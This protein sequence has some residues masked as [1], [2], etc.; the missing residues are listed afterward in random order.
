MIRT[1][2]KKWLFF[3][4]ITA[5]NLFVASRT[6]IGAFYFIFWFMVVFLCVNFFWALASYGTARLSVQR[7]MIARLQEEETL[8]IE[9]LVENKG[10]HLLSHLLIEDTLACAIASQRSV[11]YFAVAVAAKETV[12]FFTQRSCP[13][14]GRYLL[15]PLVVYFFDP[16]GL[17]FFKR[18]YPV[19]QEL[20]VYPK[21]SPLSWFPSLR[22][23]SL[24]W[25]GIE[26]T[27]TS[28]DEDEFFGIREYHAGD[29]MRRIHWLST[30][31]KNQLIVKQFQRQSFF[32]ATLVFTLEKERNYGDGKDSVAEYILRLAASVARHLL[33]HNVAVELLAHTGGL[34]HIPSSRGVEQL[35]DILTF[36]ATAQPEGTTS[37][38]EVFEELL[39]QVPDDANVIVIMLDRDWEYLIRMLPLEKRNIF[40]IPLILVSSTFRYAFEKEELLADIKMKLS[41]KFNFTPLLFS[42]G[43]PLETVFV[44]Q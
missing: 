16:C 22:K 11:R 24:P 25:F 35:D 9:T 41:H 17:F 30:A 12:S 44:G 19:Y 3:F 39:R 5:A 10:R 28:G 23:G 18:T 33:T 38:D 14:R 37:L 4:F 27:R 36:L 1:Q 2:L 6:S 26:S 13:Q 32:K 42:R 21:I 20:Y 40:F 29:P 34:V 15:G 7:R 8:A 31:R 43:Q